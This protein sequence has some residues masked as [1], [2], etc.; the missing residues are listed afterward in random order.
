MQL[1]A[2]VGRDH[3]ETG[4]ADASSEESEEI[5][6]RRVRPVEVL[7]NEE[8][9][10]VAQSVE[11]SR[12]QVEKAA[13]TESATI[14]ALGLRR[15]D[16]EV[17]EHVDQLMPGS[18]EDPFTLLNRKTVQ[19]LAECFDYR[20]EREVSLTDLDAVPDEDFAGGAAHLGEEVTHETTL[21]DACLSSHQDHPWFVGFAHDIESRNQ[22]FQFLLSADEMGTC[23]PSGHHRHDGTGGK[24][25]ERAKR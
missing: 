5:A 6:G 13:L 11:D 12:Q 17:G 1:V 8:R 24:R 15:T 7:D 22:R 14:H 18:S 19:S 3:E 25:G 20:R 23:D 9:R 16:I 21:A 2:A 10:P 4:A